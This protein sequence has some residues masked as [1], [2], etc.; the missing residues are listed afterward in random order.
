MEGEHFVTA[1][2]LNLIPDSSSSAWESETKAA[3][4]ELAVRIQLGQPSSASGDYG[5]AP[6]ASR[7]VEGGSHLEHPLLARKGSH[8]APPSIEEKEG[9]VQ[10]IE[11]CWSRGGGFHSVGPSNLPPLP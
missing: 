4:P 9:D 5:H 8:H 10:A 6:Q 1:N 3:D 11:S 7:Q 2:L